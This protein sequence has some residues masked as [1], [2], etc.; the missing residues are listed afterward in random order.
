VTKRTGVNWDSVSSIGV[1]LLALIVSGIFL[2]D[3]F[4][5]GQAPRESAVVENWVAINDEAIQLGGNPEA[6]FTITEFMDFTCPFCADL[7]LVTDTLLSVY[8]DQLQV[9]F[10][11][12][13]LRNR[14]HAE[15]AAR[16]LECGAEQ[17]RLQAMYRTLFSEQELIGSESWVYF[18]ERSSVQDIPAFTACTERDPSEF[19]RISTGRAHGEASGILGT[20][21]VWLNGEPISARSVADFVRIANERG[22]RLD[23]ERAA[24]R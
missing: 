4:L 2:H 7:A 18:A 21:T 11:H 22:A 19:R 1:L 14:E 17:G 6:D 9:R 13:P 3:R 5:S 15:P 16:A 10:H 12:F 20:P 8:G 24:S 23:P